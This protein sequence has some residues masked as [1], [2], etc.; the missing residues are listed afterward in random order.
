MEGLLLEGAKWANG[1]LQ[2]SDELRCSLPPCKLK[3]QLKGQRKVRVY[4]CCTLPYLAFFSLLLSYLAVVYVGCGGELS[5]VP[6]RRPHLSDR[7][8]AGVVAAL[9][10][11]AGM[12]P[13]R[14]GR[15]SPGARLTASE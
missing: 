7:A 1:S 9:C 4:A 8:G 11:A 15:H 12:G 10:A 6:T 14:R 13:E 2:L 3:W 5:C